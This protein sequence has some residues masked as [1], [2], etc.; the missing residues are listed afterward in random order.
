MHQLMRVPDT[1]KGGSCPWLNANGLRDGALKKTEMR[2]RAREGQG[3]KG[4]GPSFSPRMHPKPKTWGQN[5]L[6]IW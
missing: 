6:K 4:F 3:D 1:S 5:K 2:E